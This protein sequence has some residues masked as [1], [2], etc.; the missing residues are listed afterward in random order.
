MIGKCNFSHVTGNQ[1]GSVGRSSFELIMVNSNAIYS[2][3][4]YYYLYKTG[5]V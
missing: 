3:A 2:G 4:Y 5:L 1:Q